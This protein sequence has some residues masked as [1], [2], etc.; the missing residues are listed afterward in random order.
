[1]FCVKKDMVLPNFELLHLYFTLLYK[2]FSTHPTH[3]SLLYRAGLPSVRAAPWQWRAGRPTTARMGR[4]IP[5][6]CCSEQWMYY[7][8]KS[9]A[10]ILGSQ[11]PIWVPNRGFPFGGLQSNSEH[12]YL[13]LLLRERLRDS[14]SHLF[15]LIRFLKMV[16]INLLP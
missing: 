6:G 13:N 8:P 5:A 15:R 10:T 1:M 7:S 12:Y 16:S 2:A 4:I 14:I 11:I 3:P 9:G